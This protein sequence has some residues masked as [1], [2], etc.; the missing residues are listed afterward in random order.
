METVQSNIFIDYVLR[1]FVDGQQKQNLLT[2]C[3]VKAA[4]ELKSFI[5][6]F[7]LIW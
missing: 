7:I 4:Y 2:F 6:G 5:C 1:Y 3:F